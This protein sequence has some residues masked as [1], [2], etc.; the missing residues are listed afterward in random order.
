MV[1]LRALGSAAVHGRPALFFRAGSHM[2][3]DRFDRQLLRLVQE[4]AA[5]TAEQ[6]AKDVELS[7]S[8]IQRRLKRLREEGVIVRHA[9]VVDPAALG[10]PTLFI[11]SVQVERERPELLAQ[12]RKWLAAQESVQQA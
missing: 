12:F 10:R 3:L 2:E 6:L 5:L 9:A 1:R 7:P 11:T 4:D 8:A